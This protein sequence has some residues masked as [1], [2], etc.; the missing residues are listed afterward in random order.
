[1][2]RPIGETMMNTAQVAHP[3]AVSSSDD[4]ALE[5]SR[6]RGDRE[7]ESLGIVL[8]DDQLLFVQVLTSVLRAAGHAV[9]GT[10]RT[11]DELV[12]RVGAVHPDLCITEAR[13]SD[14][15]DS[16][17]VAAVLAAHP[18]TTVVVL[19]ADS[20]PDRMCRALDAGARG[21]VHKSQDLAALLDVIRRVHNGEIRV[22]LTR[23]TLPP[24]S[25]GRPTHFELLATHL[26]AR[27]LEC[28]ALLAA[29]LDTAEIAGRLGLS[30]A[31][32]RSHVQSVLTKLGAHSRV[33]A[34]SLAI[35]HGL[36]A[37]PSRATGT[38]IPQP[39][40]PWHVS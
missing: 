32:V 7:G 12:E 9:L 21:Y 6:R 27:E 8:G 40:G 22:Q 2:N 10:A 1:M 14:S 36:V 25:S 17:V 31:T 5:R 38:S 11:L 28:L 35:R 16:E 18:G 4:V 29:G 19:T 13:L 3:A 33:E 37:D 23:S 20:D 26:T 24:G 34:A 30:P 15:D 39:S